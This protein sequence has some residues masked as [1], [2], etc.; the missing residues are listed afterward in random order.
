MV[1]P[2][3]QPGYGG[4][5]GVRSLRNAAGLRGASCRQHPE[6]AATD[7]GL[8]KDNT[9]TTS[10]AALCRAFMNWLDDGPS[11][12]VPLKVWPDTSLGNQERETVW[13]GRH[14]D[15]PVSRDQ[16]SCCCRGCFGRV[17]TAIG[18]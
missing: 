14:P 18:P 17:R 7:G 2:L 9:N 4:V 10:T 5:A 12:K 6:Q 3:F 15:D 1:S 11:L 16:R 8:D 13:I